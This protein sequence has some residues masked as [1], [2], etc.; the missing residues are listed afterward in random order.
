MIPNDPSLWA[1]GSHWPGPPD[2]KNIIT[3]AD[4]IADHPTHNSSMII[5][6]ADGR[7]LAYMLPNEWND[8]TLG[9]LCTIMDRARWWLNREWPD[10]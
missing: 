10:E 9:E 7:Y 6:R 8:S 2:G 5:T 3:A 4:R 1:H